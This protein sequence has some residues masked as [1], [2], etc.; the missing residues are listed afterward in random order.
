MAKVTFLE[1]PALSGRT[2]ERYAGCSYELYHFPDLGN[3]YPMTCLDQIGVETVYIDS[4]MEKLDRA[5]FLARIEADDSDFYCIHAVVLAKPTDLFYTAEILK[6]RPGS[7]ILLHGPEATRVPQEYLTDTRVIVFRGEVEKPLVTYLQTGRL[8]GASFL[9][10]GVVRHVPQEDSGYEMDELPIPRRDHPS[11]KPTMFDFQNPKFNQGPFTT[12]LASRG[13]SFR[14]KFCVPISISF[15]RE[16]EEGT[17]GKTTR[18]KKASPKRVIEEA[19][20]LKG[21]GYRAI[22]YTDDQFLWEKSR[23]MAI[24]EGLKPLGLQWGCL[25]RADFLTDEE[26][27]KAM[28]EA[29]CVS[30]DIGVESLNQ[31]VLDEI[32]KDLKVEDV[33]VA[34]RLLKR[35]GIEP[36]FNIM[37]GT[38]PHETEADMLETVRKLKAMDVKNVM[39]TIATPFKG[40]EFYRYVKENGFLVD[41]SDAIN[42]MGKSMISYP[43]MTK[44]NLERLEKHAYRSFYLRP[45]QVVNRLKRVRTPGQLVEAAR[46][47][48]RILS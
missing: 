3:L 16:L 47:A 34:T 21:L 20:Y 1:P 24:L 31:R 7:R 38:T 5:S 30:I 6:R 19:A 37:F 44:E 42:P 18:V 10:D 17:N 28:A 29:G 4:T 8:S 33:E 15:A 36:K 48:V 22:H 2:P 27:V 9:E 12:A 39:F 45:R 35:H 46:I 11:L 43:T 26:V 32:R 41:D 14:C 23:T 25:S 13:C 40:S